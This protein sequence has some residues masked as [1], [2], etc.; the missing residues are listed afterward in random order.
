MT[1]VTATVPDPKLIFLQH[2]FSDC[3]DG[4]DEKDC[5]ICHVDQFHCGL[6]VCINRGNICDGHVDCPDG[7]DERMCCECVNATITYDADAIVLILAL[8]QSQ[9][10]NG[11]EWTRQIASVEPY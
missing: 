11:H 4:K 8:S 5:S 1:A 9:R 2:N 3:E 10:I 6:G 7:R